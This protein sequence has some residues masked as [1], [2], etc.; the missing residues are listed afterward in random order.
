MRVLIVDDV[1]ASRHALRRALDF[2]A[3]IE[4]VGEAGSGSEAIERAEDLRPDLVLMDVRMP[5]GDGVMATEHI[6]GRLPDTKVLALTVHDDVETVRDMLAAGAT[7]YLLKGAPVDDLLS[8]VRKAREGEGQID[9]RVLP[10]ALD[11]LR[12][13]LREEQERREDVERLARLRQEFIQIL[14]HELRTPLTVMAGALRFIQ[15]RGL[16][17]DEATLVASALERAAELERMVEGLELIGEVRPGGGCV[18]NP[19]QAV[20][21][22][23][24]RL[25]DRPDRVD[26]GDEA[27]PGVRQQHL[28][29][30]ARELVDN[31]IRHGRRPVT[32]T[33]RRD[34]PRVTLRVTDEGDFDPRP[35]L[36]DAFAQGDMSITR[37]RGG[38]GLGLFVAHRLCEADGGRLTLRREGGRTVAE[39]RYELPPD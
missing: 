14:S 21:E 27:W 9:A 2:D 26:A 33:A 32:V 5:N 11:D 37:E 7:G 25:R 36:F 19:A 16:R 22:A 18:A 15:R 13:L 12:R 34:G 10:A 6:T 39:A 24:E 30:V 35:E 4:V 38:M 17:D 8:A 1:E 20:R 29:R 3:E 28:T 31:A 23:L